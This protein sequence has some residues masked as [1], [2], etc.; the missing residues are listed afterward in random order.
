[1]GF[2]K[3][4][5]MMNKLTGTIFVLIAFGLIPREASALQRPGPTKEATGPTGIK[6]TVCL[7]GKYSTCVTDMRRLGW[8]ESRALADC[9]RKRD[10]GKVK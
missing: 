10:E 1:L 3:K 9:G 4:R 6:L 7:D 5:G 8:H 2:H